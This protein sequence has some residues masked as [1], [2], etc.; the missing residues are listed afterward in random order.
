M[1]TEI[2]SLS[3]PLE[4]RNQRVTPILTLPDIVAALDFYRAGFRAAEIMRLTSDTGVVIHAEMDIGGSRVVLTSDSNSFGTAPG[5]LRG[6]TVILH[7]YVSDVDESVAHAIANG[8]HQVTP[9]TDKFYGERSGTLKDPF[10]HIWCIATLQH[11][12]S[13]EEIQRRWTALTRQPLSSQ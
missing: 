10:G 3:S 2:P 8:A 5:E 11:E 4:S 9:V 6:S 7:C 13:V 1:K 12:L